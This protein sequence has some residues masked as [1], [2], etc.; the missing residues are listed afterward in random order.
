[1]TE[2]EALLR[3]I[4]RHLGDTPQAD[5]F[6]ADAIEAGLLDATQHTESDAWDTACRE[7]GAR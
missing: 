1:M 4:A 7:E 3:L 6:I 5:S 2:Q